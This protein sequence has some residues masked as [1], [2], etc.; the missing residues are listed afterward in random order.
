M[1]STIDV[2]VL[3]YAV[4]TRAPKHEPA[5]ALLDRLAGQRELFYV[6]W[7]VLLGFVRIA[8]HPSLLPRPLAVAD[9][10]TRVEHLLELPH[11]RTGSEGDGTAFWPRYVEMQSEVRGGNDVPDAQLA[12]LMKLHGVRVIHTDDRGFARFSGIEPR[13][14]VASA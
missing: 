2:N 7:P 8:T 9:A 5:L 4:N 12:G 13:P 3:V 6:F 10:L 14:L 1:S 11:L